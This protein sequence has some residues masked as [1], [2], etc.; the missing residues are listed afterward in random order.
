MTFNQHFFGAGQKSRGGGSAEEQWRNTFG[1]LRLVGKVG[2]A[3]ATLHD[4]RYPT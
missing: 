4:A 2:A 3:G 1:D